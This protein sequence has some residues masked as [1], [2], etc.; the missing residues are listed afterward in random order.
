[1][2]SQR[3]NIQGK[4]YILTRKVFHYKDASGDDRLLKLLSEGWKIATTI[5]AED[6]AIVMEHIKPAEISTA[7][8]L[9][10]MKGVFRSQ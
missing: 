2:K 3:V 10:P 1:M 7:N 5:K 9:K 4:E 6:T 8:P